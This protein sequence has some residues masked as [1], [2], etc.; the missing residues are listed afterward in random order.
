QKPGIQ[1]RG[2]SEPVDQLP[3]WN[4][5]QHRNASARD[6]QQAVHVRRQ[7]QLILNVQRDHR[8]EQPDNEGLEEQRRK[9]QPA[10][11]QVVPD[12]VQ[13][14][15]DAGK[16]MIY[17]SE[18]LGKEPTHSFRPAFHPLPIGLDS[19]RE[20]QCNQNYDDAAADKDK[21]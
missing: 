12:F 5:R 8:A 19:S 2:G 16:K 7:V 14:L 10:D 9:Y 20:E 18:Q 1:E 6:Q 17:L 13:R 15:A 21:K 11:L 3:A 4:D